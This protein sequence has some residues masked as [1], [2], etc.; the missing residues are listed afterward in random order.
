M[1][2][3]NENQ[4]NETWAN[5]VSRKKK[6]GVDMDKGRT[7]QQ[8]QQKIQGKEMD[9]LNGEKRQEERQKDEMINKLRG[10][11][12]YQREYKKE[13]TLT[14]NVKNPEQLTVMMIIKAIEDKIGIGKLYGLRKKTDYEYELTLEKETDCENLMDGIL[15][16]GQI[17]ELRKLCA[18]ERMVSFLHLPNYINDDDIL[19]KL[20]SWGVTPILPLR[21]RYY[22]ATTVADGTRYIKVKFPKDVMSLPYNTRFE[23]EDGTQ[24]FRVIHDHQVKTCRICASVDH[25]KK[26]CPQMV[27][28]ECLEQGHYARD[29]KAPRC[30]SCRKAFQRCRCEMDDEENEDTQMGAQEVMGITTTERLDDSQWQAH[31]KLMQRRKRIST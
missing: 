26:D 22:P 16:N 15:I 23:T 28:R 30:Q 8:Q 13:T 25:E 5:V 4:E 31:G 19:Q 21:R 1:E 10:K 7:E 27:F 12:R 14:M 2:E 18:T 3:N 20:T 6:N 24:F 11:M 9:H 17:C 29:C